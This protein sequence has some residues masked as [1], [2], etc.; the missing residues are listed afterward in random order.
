[1]INIGYIFAKKSGLFLGSS[2]AASKL[3]TV[4]W[5]DKGFLIFLYIFGGKQV[6]YGADRSVFSRC[7]TFCTFCTLYLFGV[8]VKKVASPREEGKKWQI[9]V[10]FFW[11]KWWFCGVGVVLVGLVHR[12][13][14]ALEGK[15]LFRAG[16]VRYSYADRDLGWSCCAASMLMC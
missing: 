13:I 9:F 7:K 1:M 4:H 5:K 12:G 16:F 8:F 3:R 14:L 15:K 10:C 6:R 11:A 2:C